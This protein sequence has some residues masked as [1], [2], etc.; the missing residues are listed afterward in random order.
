LEQYQVKISNRFAALENFGYK[1]AI[2]GHG[3]VLW[4]ISELK[5]TEHISFRV[6]AS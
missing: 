4:R 6:K 5:Q 3:T 2:N 1:A